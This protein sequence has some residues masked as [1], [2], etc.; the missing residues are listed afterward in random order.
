MRL[1]TAGGRVSQHP[2]F[3]G[4]ASAAMAAAVCIPWLGSVGL[5]DPWETHYSEVGRQMLVRG[6][7]VHPYWQDAWFFSKPALTPWLAAFGLWLSGTLQSTG[8]LPALT[9][10]CVRLPFALMAVSAV[11]V[12]AHHVGMLHHR[13]SGLLTG[14]VLA[15]SPLWLLVSRQAMTDMPFVAAVT[16]A[17]V[18]FVRMLLDN[19]ARQRWLVVG[20]VA[21]GLAVMA[22]GLLGLALPVLVVGSCV[23]LTKSLGLRASAKRLLRVRALVA[24]AVVALP[25]YLAMLAFDGVD[26]EGKTFFERFFIHDHFVRF[27]KGAHSP[28]PYGTFTYFIEQGAFG[29]FPWVGLVPLAIHRASTDEHPVLRVA[30]VWSTATFALF[31]LSAT[32]Y[33][34]YCLPMVPP[35]AVLVAVSLDGLL[36]EVKGAPLLLVGALLV[37]LVGRDLARM[38]RRW[39]ELFTYNHERPYPE[40]LDSSPIANWLPSSLDAHHVVQVCTWAVVAALVALAARTWSRTGAVKVIISTAIACALWLSWSHWV[41]FSHEW[42]QRDLFSRY[43]SQR[44]A[45]EPIAAFFMD[46]KGETFYSRNTVTQLGPAN[47]ERELPRFLGQA[48]RKWMLVEHNRLQWLQRILGPSHTVTLMEP[49]LNGKFVLL[50]VDA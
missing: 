47:W 11:G 46:W 13:R 28:S 14:V 7:L 36:D 50:L 25:W 16:V 15:T 10:W 29:F 33:H 32:R 8:E 5:W 39:V 20:W 43:W 9:E 35:L 40:A 49:S 22:K 42:T 4:L 27:T 48:G 31:T 26:N 3:V 21:V 19:Q 45:H 34:H 18:C 38:P 23:V 17:I 24:F 6:D 41:T 30:L 44:G 2:A 1:L 37:G 12:L